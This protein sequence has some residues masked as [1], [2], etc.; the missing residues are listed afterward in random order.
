MSR[1]DNTKASE[2]ERLSYE[3]RKQKEE[4]KAHKREAI[5]DRKTDGPNYPAT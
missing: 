3:Q 4:N 5:D 2:Q 1:Q